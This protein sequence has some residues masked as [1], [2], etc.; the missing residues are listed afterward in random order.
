MC[1]FYGFIVDAEAE[2]L[3]HGPNLTTPVVRRLEFI[4]D[5]D[6]C[7][8]GNEGESS[9]SKNFFKMK[10]RMENSYNGFAAILSRQFEAEAHILAWSGKGIHSNTLDWGPTMRTLWKRTL[11]SREGEWEMTSWVPD[12]VVIH[13]GGNDLLP[14][15]SLETEVIEGYTKLLDDVRAGNRFL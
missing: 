15:S 4:G 12:A 11:A 5:S 9:S 1:T 2:V 6:T 13:I 3:S 10:G 7:A 14:P 8:F